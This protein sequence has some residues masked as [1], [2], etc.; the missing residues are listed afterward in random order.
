[1]QEHQERKFPTKNDS[2][3][4]TITSYL[5]TIFFYWHLFLISLLTTTISPTLLWAQEKAPPA[6]NTRPGFFS[7]IPAEIASPWTTKART[8]LLAGTALTTS[9]LILEKAIHYPRID[10][11]FCNV[12]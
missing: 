3:T 9:I 10:K 12:T 5:F 7:N 6:L 4:K 1:M 2:K 11:L 8:W